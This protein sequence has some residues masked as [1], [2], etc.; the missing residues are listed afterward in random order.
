V[1]DLWA[2]KSDDVGL[3]G[4]AISLQDL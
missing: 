2:T 1:N 3:M 4:G